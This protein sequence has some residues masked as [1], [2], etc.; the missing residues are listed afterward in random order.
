MQQMLE[1]AAMNNR[2]TIAAAR[3]AERAANGGTPLEVAQ[4]LFNTK[5]GMVYRQGASYMNNMFGNGSHVDL[6]AGLVNSAQFGGFGVQSFGRSTQSLYGPGPVANIIAQQ[7]FREID[8][9][10]TNANGTGNTEFTQG[11]DVTT[12]GGIQQQLARTGMFAN[13]RIGSFQNNTLF[14][15]TNR[16]IKDL[17]SDGNIAGVKQVRDIMLSVGNDETKLRAAL[18]SLASNSSTSGDV[19]G[20]LDTALKTNSSF[21]LDEKEMKKQA[22]EIKKSNK[23]VVKLQN[24]Y[25]DLAKELKLDALQGITGVDMRLEGALNKAS[26]DV[27]RFTRNARAAG[28]ASDLGGFAARNQ[29]TVAALSQIYGSDS[30]AATTGHD[31]TARIIYQQRLNRASGG[32]QS[33]AEVANTVASDIAG[34]HNEQNLVE[35]RR[36]AYE[37][38]MKGPEAKAAA[39]Q[40]A[41]QMRTELD[42]V[43]QQR[44][45]SDFKTRFNISD[46][47]NLSDRDITK[48]LGE[49]ASGVGSA[50]LR[51]QA[52]YASQTVFRSWESHTMRREGID[53]AVK[54]D[55]LKM[56]KVLGAQDMANL[57]GNDPTMR[58]GI[59]KDKDKMQALADAGIDTSKLSTFVETNKE[60]LSALTQVIMDD[61]AGNAYEGSY[62]AR[63]RQT[64]MAKNAI[65]EAEYGSGRSNM[66][67]HKSLLQLGAEMLLNNTRQATE[68]DVMEYKLLSEIKDPLFTVDA[69]TGSVVLDAK[70]RENILKNYGGKDPKVLEDIL[71][72]PGNFGAFRDY[73]ETQ[74]GTLG[75]K[76]G[77]G[78]VVSEK[79]MKEGMDFLNQEAANAVRTNM[80]FKE[81][82]FKD[83]YL[84]QEAAKRVLRDEFS[85][86]KRVNVGGNILLGEGYQ[87]EGGWERRQK[88][89]YKF[90][91]SL[92]RAGGDPAKVYEAIGED[93]L[94]DD[95]YQGMRETLGFGNLS[96]DVRDELEDNMSAKDKQTLAG[97]AFN[98][99][100]DQNYTGTDEEKRV[101]ASLQ[102]LSN[103]GVGGMGGNNTIGFM[104]VEMMEV[105]KKSE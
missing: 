37:A 72:S 51:D 10:M 38:A 55:Y 93:I 24:I 40:L 100:A 43:K 84:T 17:E 57:F 59:L 7:M 27:N 25:G 85:N 88:D 66:S 13:R 31:V 9:R 101:I 26:A 1:F 87:G 62:L 99:M 69:A 96:E 35:Q 15:R 77:R 36:I 28:F 104:R 74:G 91:N 54:S 48:A 90:K 81:G 2:R 53:S 29:H 105:V 14:D 78:T 98:K 94:D 39:I 95:Q 102:N 46:T 83:G 89:A 20:M 33:D 61:S 42:P 67:S 23:I 70:Q 45:L 11:L 92:D 44:L 3:L 6:M 32:T 12:I 65:K 97:Y 71:N 82:D 49:D 22:E 68:K 30:A 60:S 18:S 63:Q 80:G 34:A 52:E 47:T 56:A 21:V 19:K 5:Q 86:G 64:E 4:K 79:Q 75:V 41:E 73:M 58:E 50:T 103:N 76:D 8:K 16:V